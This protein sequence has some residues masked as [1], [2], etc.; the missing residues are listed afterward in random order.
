MAKTEFILRPKAQ[1]DLE[2]I[3]NYTDQTWGIHQARTYLETIRETCKELSRN[4]KRG[5][6]RDEIYKGLHVYPTGKHLIFYL[7]TNK[8][9]DIVRILHESMDSNLHLT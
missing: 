1:T 6:T 2:E 8:K 4:P 5:K 7:I 3:W 9:I